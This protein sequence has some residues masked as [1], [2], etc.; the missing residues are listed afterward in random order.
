[1][2]EEFAFMKTFPSK[3]I[4]HP[5]QVERSVQSVA[6]AYDRR[7]HAKINSLG[8]H[9]PPQQGH[10]RCLLALLLSL[11][12]LTASALPILAQ[13]ESAETGLAQSLPKVELHIDK[14]T[15]STEVAAT[16]TQREIG[17]MYRSKMADN[18]GM[19]FLMGEIGPVTFWMKNTLIPLSIAFID[20]NGVILEIHD[21]Q[22]GDPT[23]PDNQLPRLHSTS[24]QV[25]YALETNLH[26]FALN[27]IKPG[28]KLDP[29]PETLAKFT[30]PSLE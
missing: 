18:N 26:W 23:I 4:C 5:E 30:T 28:D 7:R 29:P 6:A 10:G 27:G 12:W 8:G 24:D 17:L 9:R 15:L 14:A 19:I 21:M 16:T 1:M 20:K 25:A 13:T 3:T 11:L 2:N 22:P